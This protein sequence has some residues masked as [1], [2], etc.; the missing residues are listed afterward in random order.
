MIMDKFKNYLREEERR[1]FSLHL[2]ITDVY[3]LDEDPC[4]HIEQER[5]NAV[6][7]TS[8]FYSTPS[9]KPISR[10]LSRFEFIKD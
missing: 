5:P 6:Y 2:N 1:L 3:H 10:V 9:V 8:R 7:H 4:L